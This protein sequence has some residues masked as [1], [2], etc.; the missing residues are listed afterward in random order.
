MKQVTIYTCN[1]YV[2]GMHHLGG[3]ELQIGEQYYAKHEPQNPKDKKYVAIFSENDYKYKRHTL[4][5]C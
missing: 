4:G 5:C 2:V 1:M 3:K